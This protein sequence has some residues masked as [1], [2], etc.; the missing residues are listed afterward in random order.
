M[1]ENWTHEKA[2]AAHFETPYLKRALTVLPELLRL[3]LSKF[4]D[5]K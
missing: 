4:A 1:H 2:L 3:S 5:L